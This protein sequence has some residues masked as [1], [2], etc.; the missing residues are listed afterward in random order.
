M[1]SL[2]WILLWKLAPRSVLRVSRLK[3]ISTWFNQLAEVGVVRAQRPE[4]GRGFQ[5]D[6]FVAVGGEV[7][8]RF[9][10]RDR[11]G[12]DQPGG[13][14]AAHRPQRHAHGGTGRDAVIDHD[15]G[16]SGDRNRRPVAA[17]DPAAPLDLRPLPGGFG[18]DV[19]L[20]D[21]EAGDHRVIAEDD[22][23]RAI[24]HGATREE[25]F[26]AIKAAA[27]PGGGVAYSVGVRALQ[28]LEQSGVFA[29]PSA[30]PA[31]RQRRGTAAPQASTPAAS[32]RQRKT[33][34][35]R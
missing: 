32:S 12:Q 23:G 1:A 35:K 31:A 7:L 9:G 27:V 3:T 6:D 24:D 21:A 5:A 4:A 10:R 17:I 14:G 2:S 29:P 22:R 16:T 26:E 11:D 25:L 15:R 8:Q 34:T 30:P 20:G 18:L 33:A 19:A 13:A 28:E